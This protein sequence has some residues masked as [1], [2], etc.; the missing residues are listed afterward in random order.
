MYEIY[1]RYKTVRNGTWQVLIDFNI[2]SLPISVVAIANTAGIKILKNSVVNELKPGEV[3]ASVL[4]GDMWYIIYDDTVSKGRIRFTIAH[5]LGH[6]FLGHPL[7]IG[8]HARTID[9]RKPEVET[10]ADMFASRL[11]CP[12]CVLWGLN[13]HTPEEIKEVCNVSYAAAKI[14][15]ERMKILYERNKFLTSSL[16]R[17]VYNNFIDYINKNKG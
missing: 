4:D 16:E 12:A 7:K 1:G 14:R 11:L 15:S 2:T 3:G 13:L 8:Y 5:E 10:D 6:I 9:V 17:Q